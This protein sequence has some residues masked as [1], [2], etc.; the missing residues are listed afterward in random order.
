[1]R[2]HKPSSPDQLDPMIIKRGQA[3]KNVQEAGGDGDCWYKSISY[4][5]T[6]R[7]SQHQKIRKKILAFMEKNKQVLRLHNN[8]LVN[9]ND[10]LE[11]RP[12]NQNDPV[13]Y[14]IKEH[15]KPG[16]WA[17]QVIIAF[18]SCMF[19]TKINIFNS[20]AVF[21]RQIWTENVLAQHQINSNQHLICC[22]PALR[23]FDET[24]ERQIYI[25]YPPGH[26]R[27]AHNGVSDVNWHIPV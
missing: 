8:E 19:K 20:S 1:M 24:A 10:C 18:T 25:D 3:P 17:D 7:S 22:E 9:L 6:G 13:D 26:F 21:A 4:I 15:K 14:Y 27:V 12:L 23:N 16:T 11:P 5:I 2:Y